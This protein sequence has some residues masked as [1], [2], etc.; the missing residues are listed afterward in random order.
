MNLYLISPKDPN[1]K[2]LDKYDVYKSVIVAAESHNDAK[3]IHPDGE[4]RWKKIGIPGENSWVKSPKDVSSKLIGIAKLGTKRG[5][6]L[7]SFNA[8]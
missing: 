1:D 5:V 7:A 6:V 2:Y 4:K 8:G 3:K